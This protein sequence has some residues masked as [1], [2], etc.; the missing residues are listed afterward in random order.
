MYATN[1]ARDTIRLLEQAIPA[2]VWPDQWPPNSPDL[3]PVDYKIR[4]VFMSRGLAGVQHWR[5]EA[6]LARLAWHGPEHYWQCN[7]RVAFGQKRRTLSNYC[8]SVNI[9]SAI[10]H[11]TLERALDKG[12]FVCLSVC[13]IGDTHLDGSRCRNIFQPF[14]RATF[15]VSW[16]HIS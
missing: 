5:T 14:N 10:S 16:G 12:H 7:W 15:L 8:V 2:V 11:E 3:N 9:Y 6:A 13:H 1:Q 4:S